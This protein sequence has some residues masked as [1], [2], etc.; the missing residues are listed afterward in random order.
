MRRLLLTTF[1]GLLV[2][3]PPAFAETSFLTL[4]PEV[5]TLGRV[6]VNGTVE[7]AVTLT[8]TG[9]EPLTLNSFE[10]FGFNGNFMV[11]P[12]TCTLGTV[13]APGASCTFSITTSP[14]VVGAIRGQFCYTGVGAS[15]SDRECGRIVGGAIA[16]A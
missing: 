15:T 4:S 7:Q 3:A 14:S 12:G 8:N 9:S 13:L 10:A 5:V 2:A 6:P 16:S 11:N 1:V